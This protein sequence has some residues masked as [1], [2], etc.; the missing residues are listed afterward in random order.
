[1]PEPVRGSIFTATLFHRCSSV[2]IRGSLLLALATTAVQA[3]EATD[4]AE[5]QN[6]VGRQLV[7]VDGAT[8]ARLADVARFVKENRYE[9]AIRDLHEMMTMPGSPGLIPNP[10]VPRHYLTLAAAARGFLSTVPDEAF[11]IY[12]KRHAKTSENLFTAQVRPHSE[13]GLR[14]LADDYFHTPHGGIAAARLAAIAFDRG[15]YLAAATAWRLIHEKHRR[16]PSD[17]ALI[18]AKACVAYHAAGQREQSRALR[19]MAATKYP[20]ATITVAGKPVSLTNFLDGVL[21]AP[22]PD[23]PPPE[24][25]R[26]WTSMAGSPRGFAVTPD[27]DVTPCALWNMPDTN[28]WTAGGARLTMSRLRGRVRVTR[29][30]YAGDAGYAI[31]LPPLA[32]PVVSDGIVFYRG[33]DAV[34]AMAADSGR[35][36]WRAEGIPLYC[37]KVSSAGK[38]AN[39]L[40]PLAGDMG[41]LAMTVTDGRLFS[42]CK[43]SSVDPGTVGLVPSDRQDDGSS[44]VA[45]AVDRGGARRLWEVGNGIGEGEQTSRAKYLAAPT[46]SEGRL[47]VATR[48]GN[49]YHAMCLDAST[50]KAIW[51]TAL[52]G[53][54]LRGG[55][56]LSW[57]H[58]YTLEV[59][60]ERGSPAA[61]A[62]G[63]AIFIT[64][65]GLVVALDAGTGAPVWA[66]QYPSL[67]SG[68]AA[69]PSV[70][71][72][73]GQ[74][75]WFA[76]LR[77][78]YMPV[79]PVIVA[80][81][82]VICLPCDSPNVFALNAATGELLWQRDRERQRDLTGISG[83]EV[84]LSGPDVAILRAADGET[85][86]RAGAGFLGRPAVTTSGLLAAGDGCIVRL[87][88][89]T[90]KIERIPVGADG[91]SLG[92]LVVSG[93]ALFSG[94]T[95]GLT[96]FAGF[97]NAWRILG[98]A[99]SGAGTPAE[100][101]GHTLRRGLIAASA[102]RL[103][104]A[105]SALADAKKADATAP[106]SPAFGQLRSRLHD[107]WLRRASA[108]ASRQAADDALRRAAE[109]AS[110][111]EDR[112]RIA[113]ETV[114]FLERF[115][116]PGR[117]VEAA[118]SL[119]ERPLE[120]GDKT[121]LA[122]RCGQR[123]VR[124]LM[125]K[126]GDAIYAKFDTEAEKAFNGTAGSADH[127]AVAAVARHWPHAKTAGTAMSAA[128]AIL[129]ERALAA[130][131]PD[132]SVA[133]KASRFLGEVKNSVRAEARLQAAAAQ[134]VIDLRFR[135]GVASALHATWSAV[136]PL[137]RFRFGGFDGNAGDLRERIEKAGKS[138]P[139]GT[140]V[141]FGGVSPPLRP[142]Y[143]G[144]GGICAILRN[145]RGSAVRAGERVF[146]LS[147]GKLS[148]M[149][150]QQD[151][152]EES[153]A[154]SADFP[155]EPGDEQP[156]GQLT[157]DGRNLAVVDKT[158]LSLLDA[159]TGK[160][161]YRKPLPLLR[162]SRDGRLA[163]DG[164]WIVIATGAGTL[165]CVAVR[166][167]ELAWQ[168]V[169]DGLDWNVQVRDEVILVS[170]RTT[171]SCL[172]AR[173]GRTMASFPP[174]SPRHV[175]TVS[176]LTPEWLT[177]S[178]EEGSTVAVRDARTG[179][180][181]LVRRAALDGAGWRFLGVGSRYV[182]MHAP[183]DGG[184]RILDMADLSRRIEPRYGS[185]EGQ[186]RQSVRAAF[187]G[188][189]AII[190]HARTAKGSLLTAPALAAVELPTGRLLWERELAP[191][192]VG[193]CR[194]G[195]LDVF[196]GAIGLWAMPLEGVE[197][198]R[199][200]IVDTANGDVCDAAAVLP[201]DVGSPPEGAT[202]VVLNGRVIVE[203]GDGIACLRG[204]D[205]ETAVCSTARRK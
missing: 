164:D 108:A 23:V 200:Y 112:L 120:P 87:A 158:M 85:V 35:E 6:A 80:Q 2:F 186:P 67:V 98:A 147:Q 174:A 32:H 82:R 121:D 68:V 156:V 144:R 160:L 8:A 15:E 184:V 74:L 124:R 79:N 110:T 119:S 122:Y 167:G 42:V 40:T 135:P 71:D 16:P 183:S 45:L 105:S 185:A 154:W 33:E 83:T 39:Y 36:L 51:D 181:N 196:G 20:A 64:N 48:Q 69:N 34:L 96:A 88:V 81:G 137:A 152:Q 133:M 47:Y 22:S 70:M 177:V 194:V 92:T 129:L 65:T 146:L 1:L 103:D 21:G 142:V 61:V 104:E 17:R 38:A 18:L 109:Y 59:I 149:D 97:E 151:E 179:D 95:G 24:P 203:H 114:L 117:A 172:D 57:Q 78:P 52:G 150:A 168:T 189:R 28:G 30:A 94:N 5:R 171:T 72:T 192:S 25:A 131:P 55:E 195:I 141:E 193:P 198:P 66:Y 50:G 134:A 86:C 197:R 118:Q 106:G 155:I 187:V 76:T 178:I 143:V 161:V 91:E 204:G 182:A 10:D 53:I 127:A 93:G 132:V 13:G 140:E 100:R 163:G 188:N 73:H 128:A 99:I 58:A 84:A 107:G 43:F 63:K 89:G 3:Q 7:D 4:A 123:E 126:H 54:P 62:G 157:S 159:C 26:N 136:D 14:R 12:I 180:S 176:M 153:I 77:R 102:D 44:L 191:A 46:C 202:P 125:A 9:E 115:D 75:I 11:D 175:R 145:A 169:V 29:T 138:L 162:A 37:D 190:L 166:N 130:S 199:Q 19:D 170:G 27:C 49:R 205:W 56:L 148:C 90:G 201:D 113:Q 60:T 139:S 41:R 111:G 173:T 165:A 101:A 116:G 31:D